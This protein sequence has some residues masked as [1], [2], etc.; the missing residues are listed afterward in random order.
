MCS[1]VRV[2]MPR[3]ATDAG[4]RRIWFISPA[5]ATI[6]FFVVQVGLSLLGAPQHSGMA[7]LAPRTP[8]AERGERVVQAIEPAD[9]VLRAVPR[10]DDELQDLFRRHRTVQFRAAPA[11]R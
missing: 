3:L 7:G 10:D 5:L 11:P 2:W 6:L 9:P 1:S 8:Q 4:G